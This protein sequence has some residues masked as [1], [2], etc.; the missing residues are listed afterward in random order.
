MDWE[1]WI[2]PPSL[3]DKEARAHT[4]RGCAHTEDTYEH[5]KAKMIHLHACA[6]LWGRAH[7]A[8][9]KK[10][11][12]GTLKCNTYVHTDVRKYV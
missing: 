6:A 5:K 1:R 11:V 9:I 7:Q 3:R 10:N 12:H 4:A 8:Q 2:H